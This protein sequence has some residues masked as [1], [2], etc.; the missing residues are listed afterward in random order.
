MPPKTSNRRYTVY[1]KGRLAGAVWGHLVGDAIGVP[2]EFNHHIETVELRGH[3]SHNQPPGTWSDDG[4]LM[5]ALL[6]SLVSVGFDPEDQGR[7]ALA[8]AYA[9]A[10]TPD[11]DGRFDI[12]GATHAALERLRR[13]TP[14]IDAGGT[15]E[16][17]QGN[18][19]LMRI[20][21]I[22]LVDV[23]AD[24]ATLVERA[25]LASRVTH[26]HP[27]C[28]VACALYV[29]IAPELLRGSTQP[30]TSLTTSVERL[31]VVYADDPAFGSVLEALLAHRSS[32]RKPGGGWVLDSFWSAWEAFAASTSYRDAIERA[33]TYGHD[34][35][36][37]AAIAGGLAG[38]RWG[39]DERT[40]G[41]PRQWLTALR[42]RAIVEELLG[43]LLR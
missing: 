28:Q 19:S 20:L 2:Y 35:D 9:G 40:D 27:N 13:G 41:I 5:L 32:V 37:T 23:P 36:T 33:V 6:D 22:A 43:R 11:G 14:A 39:L 26:G 29:L 31:R 16:R 25:H 15:G 34:T 38:L 18:G 10:Y 42:G 7:R 21:P 8:W 4:A 3:G 24:D 17:D 12:G 1:G 30:E